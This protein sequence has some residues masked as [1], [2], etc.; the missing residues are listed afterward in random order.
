MLLGIQTRESKTLLSENGEALYGLQLTPRDRRLCQVRA[1]FRGAPPHA[2]RFCLGRV[3]S[4]HLARSSV[5][6]LGL[7]EAVHGIG[8]CATP[9]GRIVA[10]RLYTDTG[11]HVTARIGECNGP[12]QQVWCR[13]EWVVQGVQLYFGGTSWLRPHASLLGLRPLCTAMAGR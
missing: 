9:G 11:A 6:V 3:T 7:G 12:Y 10:V 13:G 4:R 5:A 1:F 8:S 2:A